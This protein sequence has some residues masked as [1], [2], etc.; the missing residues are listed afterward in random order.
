MLETSKIIGVVVV[1]VVTGTV[2]VGDDMIG[3]GVGTV[4]PMMMDAVAV[5]VG[6]SDDNGVSV[7][8]G[9]NSAGGVGVAVADWLASI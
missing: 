4:P 8:W 9:N 3:V 1:R 7:G 6:A 5:T 2:G